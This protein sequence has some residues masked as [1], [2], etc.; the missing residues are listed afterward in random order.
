MR[1]FRDGDFLMYIRKVKGF[2]GYLVVVNFGK[3]R[4]IIEF[5]LVVIG[6]S[7]RVK[8]VFYIYD[9]DISMSLENFCVLG[10]S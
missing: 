1:V 5:L 8:V 7:K 9:I 6:I 2:F 10:L 3:D 4:V